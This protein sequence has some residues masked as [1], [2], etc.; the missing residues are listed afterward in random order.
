MDTVQRLLCSMAI[1]A[2]LFGAGCREANRDFGYVTGRVT[3]DGAAL[4]SARLEFQPPKGPPSYGVTNSGGDYQLMLSGDQPG[5]KVGIH[6]VRI[7]TYHPKSNDPH[8]KRSSTPEP[9]PAKYNAQSILSAE[10]EPGKN[11]IDFDLRRGG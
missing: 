8:A 7:T 2:V 3:L 11:R 10:V 6:I 4:E 1:L 9:I 5:A